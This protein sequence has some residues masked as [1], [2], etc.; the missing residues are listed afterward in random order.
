[1]ILQQ[2]TQSL[3]LSIGMQ[4]VP[5]VPEFKT[6]QN[7]TVHGENLS[8]NKVKGCLLQRLFLSELKR[9]KIKR[10]NNLN[11]RL[12]L[13]LP[14]RCLVSLFLPFDFICKQWGE[15]MEINTEEPLQHLAMLHGVDPLSSNI[16]Y[17]DCQKDWK[18]Q[19]RNKHK[20]LSGG[21]MVLEFW[22]QEE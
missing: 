21:G 10:L 5:S 7:K 6:K 3:S 2:G 18:G 13:T 20:C 14:L 11:N 22:R 16:F 9:E 15:G 12:V 4:G 1:M 19:G 8:H 17:Y